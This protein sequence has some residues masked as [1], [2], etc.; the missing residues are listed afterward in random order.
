MAKERFFKR[1]GH[2]TPSMFRSSVEDIPIYRLKSFQHNQ[3]NMTTRLDELRN[4][5]V[6]HI[7]YDYLTKHQARKQLF[8]ERKSEVIQYWDNKE[9]LG[10]IHIACY[11]VLDK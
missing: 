8:D 11:E 5:N 6:F 1:F 2:G 3:I 7:G 9:A 10:A 4:E